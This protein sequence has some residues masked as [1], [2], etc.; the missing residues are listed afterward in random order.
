VLGRLL[1]YTVG[2]VWTFVRASGY[3]GNA[4]N[5]TFA[6][7]VKGVTSQR[8]NHRSTVYTRAREVAREWGTCIGYRETFR[9]PLCGATSYI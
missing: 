8:A 7:R 3:T 5:A 1:R 6:H 4:A 2:D 9:R